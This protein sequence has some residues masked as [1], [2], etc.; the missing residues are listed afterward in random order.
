MRQ[1]FAAMA[2]EGRLPPAAG[3]AWEEHLIAWQTQQAQGTGSARPAHGYPLRL[4]CA[5]TPLPEC[6]AR[7]REHRA[8]LYYKNYLC[9]TKTSGAWQK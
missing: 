3:E 6:C 1:V 7:G 5:Q 8:I 2:R 9:N 4:H